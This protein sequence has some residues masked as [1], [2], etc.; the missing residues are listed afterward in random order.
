MY[1]QDI[2]EYIVICGKVEYK[3]ILRSKWICKNWEK[4][5]DEKWILHIPIF[6]TKYK[7]NY[8]DILSFNNFHLTKMY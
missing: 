2:E 7:I 6:C 8:M 4:L 5:F 3:N 1:A